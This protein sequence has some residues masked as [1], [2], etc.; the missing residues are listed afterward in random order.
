M[1]EKKMRATPIGAT[2]TTKDMTKIANTPQKEKDLSRVLDFFRYK[3]GTSLD[4]AIST[5]ILRN[6]V[7]WYIRS[8]EDMGL[9]MAVKVGKDK[10]TGFH[11]KFYSAN[12]NEWP[13]N[14]WVQLNIWEG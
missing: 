14:R 10:T 13:C 3:V 9:L 2:P 7:T 4:C 1:K 6:S 8:L 12:R 5:K 11:A